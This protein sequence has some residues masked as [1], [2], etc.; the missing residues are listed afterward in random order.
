[1]VNMKNALVIG[2]VGSMIISLGLSA[3]SVW[4]FFSFFV[5]LFFVVIIFQKIND[6]IPIREVFCALMAL[7]MLVGPAL[8]YN[9]FED[10]LGLYKMKVDED[11]YY[12]YVFPAVI[13]FI[14]G[15]HFFRKSADLTINI[16]NIVIQTSRNKRMPVILIIAGFLASFLQGFFPSE[17]KFFFYLMSALKYIGLFLLLLSNRKLNIKWLVVIYGSIVVSSFS[18]AMFHDLMIWSAFLGFIFAL[19]YKPS[20][21]IKIAGIAGFVLFAVF[22]QTIK[23]TLRK[24]L[25]AEDQQLSFN[26][27]EKVSETSVNENQ[28]LFSKENLAPN[29]TRINQ[30]HIISS[31]LQRVPNF[32][33]HTHGNLLRLYIEAALLPRFV[34]PNKI[35]AGNKELFNKYSGFSLQG[36]TSMGLSSVGDGYIEFGQFGGW[37]FMFVYGLMFSYALRRINQIARSYPIL[38]LFAFIIFLYPIR[39]DCET[40]TILGHFFK[41]MFFTWL[42]LQSFKKTFR[43]SP[44]ENTQ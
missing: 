13:S 3:F 26:L 14:A 37:I 16:N 17:I 38:P 4:A 25:W 39:P 8:A 11:Y 2:I 5:F 41:S 31:I 33:A 18:Q 30:G 9:G 42:V 22:I 6:I 43:L 1:M 21:M 23:S 19:K 40:Q 32:E 24:S 36:N 27:I 34:A 29:I 35:Q 20:T 12:G 10:Y 15:L 7:Q 28:G 44:A